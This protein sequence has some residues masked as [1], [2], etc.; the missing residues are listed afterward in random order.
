MSMKA[1]VVQNFADGLAGAIVLLL[2]LVQLQVVQRF[3]RESNPKGA[4]NAFGHRSVV[5][6]GWLAAPSAWAL[7]I[8]PVFCT[9]VA[10]PAIC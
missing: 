2:D 3:D 10:G 4:G 1:K 5:S 8:P 9:M 6:S 7:P